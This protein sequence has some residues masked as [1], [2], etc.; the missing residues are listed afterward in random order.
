MRART[1][2]FVATCSLLVPFGTVRA[3]DGDATRYV[4]PLRDQAAA[5]REVASEVRLFVNSGTTDRAAI[6][7]VGDR[8]LAAVD[9]FG[10]LAAEYRAAT[11]RVGLSEEHAL[12]AECADLVGFIGKAYGRLTGVAPVPPSEAEV[13]REKGRAR[14]LL[15]REVPRLV[16]SR[17]GCDGA[18][19]LLTADSFREAAALAGRQVVE[20]V[21]GE[22]DAELLGLVDIGVAGGSLTLTTDRALERL[23]TRAI[24]QLVARVTP[25]AFVVELASRVIVRWVGPRLAEALRNKG[26]L[27]ER[28]FASLGVVSEAEQRLNALRPDEPVRRARLALEDAERALRSTEHLVYDLANAGRHDLLG[29]MSSAMMRLRRVMEWTRHRFLIGDAVSQQELAGLIAAVNI[30]RAEL[31]RMQAEMHPGPREPFVP[32]EPL[33]GPSPDAVAGSYEVTGRAWENDPAC[34]SRVVLT[35]AMQ[36]I[37]VSFKLWDGTGVTWNYV[38]RA[39]WDGET[40]TVQVGERLGETRKTRALVGVAH[41]ARYPGA[42]HALEVRAE[43]DSD[44]RWRAASI[45]IGGNLFAL[46]QVQ[47]PRIR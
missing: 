15:E 16:A 27:E 42:Q 43:L 6:R 31:A 4:G 12:L 32:P 21:L 14:E 40:R 41:D 22:L 9:A 33:P 5:L 19:E 39:T 38:G 3:D 37:E 25:Q 18:A 7:A 10:Q 35:G 30:V 26:N 46:V 20:G 36:A 11:T 8:A 47:T 44:G 29:A 24:G 17:L 34:G 2:L 23:L 28:V 45:S 1:L 13:R